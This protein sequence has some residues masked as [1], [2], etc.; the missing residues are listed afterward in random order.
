MS[1]P[2]L[3]APNLNEAGLPLDRADAEQLR[4]LLDTVEDWLLHAS[5]DALDDLGRFLAGFAWA[6]FCPP[7]RLAA[8]LILDLGQHTVTLHTAL[9]AASR[10]PS[11]TQTGPAT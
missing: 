11:T 5:F 4:R 2:D 9:R 7:E 10:D 3:T 1:E 8:D 6:P